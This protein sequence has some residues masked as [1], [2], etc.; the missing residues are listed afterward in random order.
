MEKALAPPRKEWLDALRGLAIFLVVLLHNLPVGEEKYFYILLTGPI[1]LPLFFAISGYVFNPREGKQGIFFLN[2]LRKILIPSLVLFIGLHAPSVLTRGFSYLLYR[3]RD[4]FT[5]DVCWY[6]T[7]C[8]LGEIL[9]FYNL[10]FCKKE[11]QICLTAGIC[12]VLGFVMAAFGFGDFAMLNRAFIAQAFLLM[13]YLFRRHEEFFKKLHWSVLLVGFLLVAVLITAGYFLFPNRGI[14]V[15]MNNYYGS[16][17]TVPFS[18]LLI[19]LFNLSLMTLGAKLGRISKILSLVGQHTLITYI[20][21]GFFL[22]I[23]MRVLPLGDSTGILLIGKCLLLTAFS[24]GMCTLGGVIINW[25][26]P[27][28]MGR[29]RKKK[30]KV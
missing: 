22:S 2:V 18:F 25:V 29:K 23:G 6:I 11:W 12:C 10:K 16:L 4:F 20:W 1:K 27:E 28:L 21:H 3:L 19:A 17:W 15:H 8:I 13:G 30:E 9:F 14:D 26:F 5:G 24:I 7:A